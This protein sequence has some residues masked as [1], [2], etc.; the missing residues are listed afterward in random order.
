MVPDHGEDSKCVLSDHSQCGKVSNG[1][2]MADVGGGAFMHTSVSSAHF[3]H[4]YSGKHLNR[5]TR[6]IFQMNIY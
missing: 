1:T 3:I 4:T 6:L 2:G 5:A